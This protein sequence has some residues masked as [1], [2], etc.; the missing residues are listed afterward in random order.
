MVEFRKHIEAVEFQLLKFY[1]KAEGRRINVL[2]Q[3]QK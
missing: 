2:S 1:L 3:L